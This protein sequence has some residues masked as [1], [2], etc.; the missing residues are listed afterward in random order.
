MTFQLLLNIIKTNTI[1]K[2]HYKNDRFYKLETVSGKA[3]SNVQIRSIHLII[4][5]TKDHILE[6]TNAMREKV[7]YEQIENQK[8]IYTQFVNEW[9]SFYADYMEMKPK[10]T[11]AEG[12]SLKQI[13]TY[14]KSTTGSEQK[15]LE[16]W[17]AL[18]LNWKQLDEFH[19]RN[20]DLKYINSNLN[21][22]LNNVKRINTETNG[23]VS[24]D[25]L[26]SIINDL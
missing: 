9:F 13:I 1:L 6:Y 18:L 10:F 15:A 11:K 23:G 16:L 5:P 26:Q 21:R 4:P 2:L 8:S 3:L 17:Q 14:L 20:T 19:Q 12:G 7:T 22:I 24:D 25:Y